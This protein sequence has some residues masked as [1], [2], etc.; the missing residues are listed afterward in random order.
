MTPISF[1]IIVSVLGMYSPSK[2]SGAVWELLITLCNSRLVN[3]LIYQ[4]LTFLH[5]TQSPWHYPVP[6]FTTRTPELPFPD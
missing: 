2:F 3:I 1:L 5:Q 6:Y 4:P